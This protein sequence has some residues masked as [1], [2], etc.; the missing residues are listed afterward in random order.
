MFAHLWINIHRKIHSLV[1][2]SFSY[3][4]KS[5]ASLEMQFSDLFVLTLS[6]ILLHVV[7]ASLTCEQDLAV[8]KEKRL[9]AIRN[10]ILS[11]LN[12][13]EAPPNPKKPRTVTPELLEAYNVIKEAFEREARAR[14]TGCVDNNYFA[15]KVSLFSPQTPPTGKQVQSH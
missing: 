6:S 12:M 9:G 1:Y 14:S 3:S 10:Q 8:V 2:S 7:T 11:K 4:V 15:R 13:T 5:R